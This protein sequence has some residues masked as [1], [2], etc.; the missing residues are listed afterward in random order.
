MRAKYLREFEAR[1]LEAA[2]DPQWRKRLRAS[3]QLVAENRRPV[4][5]KAWAAQ[6]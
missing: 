6:R 3:E 4:E 1:V 5:G 2:N